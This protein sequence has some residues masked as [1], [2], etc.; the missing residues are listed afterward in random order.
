MAKTFHKPIFTEDLSKYGAFLEAS[1]VNIQ[2][3]IQTM[4]QEI[5]M[6]QKICALIKQYETEGV[7]SKDDFLS[8][9]RISCP[10][11]VTLNAFE[12]LSAGMAS[13]LEELFEMPA[14]E[15]IVNCS[16]MKCDVC[17]KNY[18]NQIARLLNMGFVD[19]K[20]YE[21]GDDDGNPDH[22]N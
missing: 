18:I 14:E 9:S 4:Q 22:T 12:K 15:V 1:D 13:S 8:L 3:S 19:V 17:W 7:A 20:V 21:K 10:D 11:F 5:E 6:H 2:A 16:K